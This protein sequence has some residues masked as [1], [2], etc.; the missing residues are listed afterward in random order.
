VLEDALDTAPPALSISQLYDRVDAALAETFGVRSSCWVEGEI[1]KLTTANGHCYLDLVDPDDRSPRPAVLGGKCWK[2][3]WG[4][5]S[6]Q[7]AAAG[8]TLA[9][10]MRIRVRGTVDLYRPQGKFGFVISEL[11]VTALL[12][13][14][15]LARAEVIATLRR[16]GLLAKN[17]ALPVPALPLRI[18][19]VASAGTEGYA[20]FCGQL[21]R[22]GFGFTVLHVQATVQGDRAPGEVRAGLVAL[23]AV[24]PPVDLIVVARGGG[25]KTDLAAFDDEGLARAVAASPVPVWTGIG[26]SGDESICDLV[27]GRTHI[28]PTACGAA[29][30]ERVDAFVGAVASAAVSI[31]RA[32]TALLDDVAAL[33]TAATTTLRTTASAQLRREELRLGSRCVALVRAARRQCDATERAVAATVRLAAAGSTETQ[34]RRGFALVRDD[35]GQLVR[36]TSQVA[37]GDRVA[38]ALAD[39]TFTSTVTE[40]TA[41]RSTP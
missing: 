38:V 41:E 1:S 40:V 34:L 14:M 27:A 23:G 35:G 28:T 17:A 9:A 31:E 36:S 4:A 22:S 19:L 33:A 30:V 21:E 26:H 12:G 3:Q 32:A 24:Q 37:V 15:A 20:D 29:I 2:T 6:R 13:A 16:E 8:V 11:D 5:I 25:A 18:G 39:G 7:L 10:G